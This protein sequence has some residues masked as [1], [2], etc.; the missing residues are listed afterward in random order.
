MEDSR[1]QKDPFLDIR[2]YLMPD[3][4]K[5]N[6]NHALFLIKSIVP[7]ILIAEML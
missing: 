1:T 6:F 7:Q 5:R 3:Q 2:R 4:G